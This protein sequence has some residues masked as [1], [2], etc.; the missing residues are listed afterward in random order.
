MLC[1]FWVPA[2]AGMTGCSGKVSRRRPDALYFLWV[3]ASGGMTGCS[4][5][6]S[7]RGARKDT[8]AISQHRELSARLLRQCRE[9]QKPYR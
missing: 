5:K 7:R 8:Q 3:P 6:V 9:W 4:G 1:L 2:F